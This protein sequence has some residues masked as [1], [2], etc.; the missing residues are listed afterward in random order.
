MKQQGGQR[1]IAFGRHPQ[2]SYADIK[3]C[4]DWLSSGQSLV[5]ADAEPDR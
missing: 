1:I 4:L 3:R 2:L 5:E